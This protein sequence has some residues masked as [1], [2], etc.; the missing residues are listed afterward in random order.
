MSSGKTENPE[1]VANDFRVGVGLFHG[2]KVACSLRVAIAE[3]ARFCT[4]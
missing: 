2:L 4:A 3:G 1:K